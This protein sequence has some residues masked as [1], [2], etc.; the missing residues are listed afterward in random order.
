M[1]RDGSV[2]S[3]RRRRRSARVAALAALAALPALVTAPGVPAPPAAAG[4]D[5]DFARD[6]VPLLKDS[7]C[8][9]HA[10]AQPEAGLSFEPFATEADARAR[11]GVW[12]KVRDKL[13]AGEMPPPSA[14]RPEEK[15]LAAA[16]RWLD[17]RLR[18][19]PGAWPIDPGRVTIRRL[20]RVEFE[21][22][23]RDLFDTP[24]DVAAQLPPDE[25]GYGFDNMGDVL[26]VSPLLLEKYL[27]AAERIAAAVVPGEELRRAA[28]RHFE[29]EAIE[30][31]LRNCRF[32]TIVNL[33]S[34][35]EVFTALDLPRDGDYVLRVRAC[36]QQAGPEPCRMALR[37]GGRDLVHVD[38]PQPE[39][40]PATFEAPVHLAGG[41]QKIAAA[42]LNDYY[43]PED[44]DPK[45]RDRNL[46]VD[47]LELEG[48]VDALPPTPSERR[49]YVCATKAANGAA[50]DVHEHAH[51][52]A[53]APAIV[54]EFASSA[55]RRPARDDEVARLLA[56]VDAALADGES[57]AHAL[58]PAVAAILVSPNFLFR[59]EIDAAPDDERAVHP[60]D[61]FELA[62]RLSYFLWSSLP[63][64][65][66]RARAARHELRDPEVLA[67]EARR[68]LR[69][70]RA[71]ALVVNFADQWLQ[72]R[73]LARAAPDSA[74]FPDFDEALRDAMR[75][76]TELFVDAVFREGRPL[77]ELVD[78]D[79]TFLNER[80]ARHYGIDGVK[81]E[82]MRRVR[83]ADATRGGVLTQASL[84]TLTSNPTRT[85][86]VKRGKFLLERIL[87]APTP[88]P[89]PGVGA[90]D[91]SMQ[92]ASAQSMKERL[93][94]HRA[95]PSCAV[96]HEKMDALGFALEH[97]GPTGAWREQDGAHLIDD[98]SPLPDGRTLAG[99]AGLKHLVL[100][101]DR[102]TR[103]LAEKLF[104]YAVGRG[105]TDDDLRAIALLVESFGAQSPSFEELVVGLVRLDAFRRRHGEAPAASGG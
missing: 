48:P 38:V 59:S 93:A 49:L 92:A 24:L 52:R 103:C 71:D 80:L 97:F 13:H 10:G 95:N 45:Q 79:F 3:S 94:A 104:T 91:E 39:D 11:A 60:L 36:G 8:D 9:C 56:L 2:D 37:A 81:G 32:G 6:V 85:S 35:G 18:A 17:V 66:L 42:F 88:P 98:A 44:P 30:A 31:T 100:E 41:R 67:G 76:E 84:L 28:V 74:L 47:W 12:R 78:A 89:P 101:G 54:A 64:A 46:I 72:L 57:F 14:P 19:G 33:Y 40:E 25:V 82:R 22:S 7:C 90:L 61:D 69:D 102:F 105:P 75:L 50:S 65:P 55:W 4:E 77:R 34:D 15:L 27:A 86:P 53:C 16:Q 1:V 73:S 26:S 21:N 20:N 70:V 23:V 83:L 96:C 43:H 99:P 63:D 87:G 29:A 5:V 51:G 58:R 68:L 62:A